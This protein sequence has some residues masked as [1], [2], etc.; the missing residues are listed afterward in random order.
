MATNT[1]RITD[2]TG[3]ARKHVTQ[4]PDWTN[5]N[6]G[7]VALITA[8]WH[9]Y[10]EEGLTVSKKG[11][12]KLGLRTGQ[13]MLDEGLVPKDC[14]ATE[15]GRFTLDLMDLTGFHHYE[16]LEATPERY[17]FRV[18][19]YPYLEPYRYLDAPRD[20]CDIPGFWDRGCLATIN[21]R[22]R[23]SKPRCFNWGDT[24]CRWVYELADTADTGEP[25]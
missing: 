18:T 23:M 8:S 2:E 25:W 3:A 5:P 16:E 9:A 20:I 17:Q 22:I 14:T 24:E 15:W 1:S 4:A 10:G 7:M 19:K 11:L 13:Y 21:P 12:F 6:I